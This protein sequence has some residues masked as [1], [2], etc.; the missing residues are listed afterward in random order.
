MD[1]LV[2]LSG[3]IDSSSCIAFYARLAHKISGVFIDYGQPVR[4]RE[5][6]SAQAVANHYRI[7]LSIIHCQ[8][9]QISYAGEIVARNAFLVS[10]GLMFHQ[11]L[12]G[13]LAIGIHSGTNYYDCSEAFASEL[14]SLVSGCTSGKVILGVPFLAWDKR[15]VFDFAQIANVPLEL[16]WSC[17]TNPTSP[18][19]GCASCRDRE[20]LDVRS[21]K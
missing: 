8:G 11:G 12:R 2:L 14:G 21:P 16:T 15:M 1:T 7:P 17:E 4:N 6:A 5:R 3:G 9:P 18:C 20:A 13:I 19:G 10:V